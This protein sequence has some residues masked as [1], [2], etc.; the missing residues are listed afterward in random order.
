MQTQENTPHDTECFPGSPLAGQLFLR[1]RGL[2]CCCFEYG[3]DFFSVCF[4][5]HTEYV[6]CR[7]FIWVW[8]VKTKLKPLFFRDR[9]VPL[10]LLLVQYMRSEACS[11]QAFDRSELLCPENRLLMVR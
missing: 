3:F 11:A 6:I 10:L 5:E 7:F 2:A 8:I 4:N 1:V 9:P